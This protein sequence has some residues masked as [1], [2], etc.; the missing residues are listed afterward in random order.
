MSLPKGTG[1][2]PPAVVALAL[3][4]HV[5]AWWQNR[6]DAGGDDTPTPLPERRYVAGGAPREVAWDL[7]AGQVTVAMER[8][9]T[10]IDPTAPPG[11]IRAP[12]RDPANVGRINRSLL[13]E[14]QVVRVAPGLDGALRTPSRDVLHEH[15]LMVLADAGHLVHCIA[16]ALRDGVL[17]REHVAQIN[18]VLG[19][20]EVLGPS[21]GAAAAACAVTVP[22][23]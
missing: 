14:V 6:I 19:D 20:A 9:I 1:P 8:I 2:A 13:L 18:A 11:A 10:G 7:T 15:G 4:D 23:L 3:L 16:D 17:Q 22:L 5:Q 12:R 21:G